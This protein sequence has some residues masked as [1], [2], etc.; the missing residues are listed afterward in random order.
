METTIIIAATILAFAIF[1][2]LFFRTEFT[3]AIGRVQKIGKD[4][5]F[6]K[7]TRMPNQE[8]LEGNAVKVTEFGIEFLRPEALGWC[9]FKNN[10]TIPSRLALSFS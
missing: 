3:A 2:V 6:L 9:L 5:V 1:F 4:G 10:Q 8:E 7:E